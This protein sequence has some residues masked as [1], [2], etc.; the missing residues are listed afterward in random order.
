[1]WS[2]HG[3]PTRSQ[4]NR[5][6]SV[7][8]KVLSSKEVEVMVLSSVEMEFLSS[9]EAVALSSL[10]VGMLSSACGG[11]GWRYF[12]AGQGKQAGGT[13]KLG[14]IEARGNQG[15]GALHDD[16]FRAN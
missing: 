13:S 8:V 9:V 15:H 16:G 12:S 14:T 6:S 5:C 10:E 7:E 11:G 1:M 3:A 2:G 4:I